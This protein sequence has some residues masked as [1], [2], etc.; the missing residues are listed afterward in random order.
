M[1][2]VCHSFFECLLHKR[3]K[4]FYKKILKKE[5]V[6]GSKATE[7]LIK[8]LIKNN[9]LP[10]TEEVF[11]K[12]DKMIQV[13]LKSDFFVAGGK[14]VGNEYRFKIQNESPRYNIFGTIDRITLKGKYVYIDDFKSSKKKYEGDEVSANVQALMYSLAAKKLWPKLKPIVRFIFLQF[15]K[16][17]IIKIEYSEVMLNGFEEYLAM[18]QDKIDNFTISDAKNNFAADKSFGTNTFTGK[19]ICGFATKPGELKKDGTKKWHCPYKFPYDYFALIKNNK[20]IKTSIK[21]SELQ[22][23]EGETVETRKYLGCPR[24]Q[25]ILNDIK[26]NIVLDKKFN[27]ILDDF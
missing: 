20:V 5:S 1:G 14:I 9:G 11:D 25:N 15:P 16:D 27:N 3:H 8:K 17:P 18:I 13:G 10:E 22:P 23:K 21:L 7:K 4:H 2:N 6:K 24:F 26:V 19:L 12:I